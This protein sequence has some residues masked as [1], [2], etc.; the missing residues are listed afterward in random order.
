[1]SVYILNSNQIVA[2]AN[3]CVNNDIDWTGAYHHQ[4]K[5]NFIKLQ[6]EMKKIADTLHACNVDAFNYRYKE[7]E[8]P[9]QIEVS[10]AHAA[11]AP[12]SDKEIAQTLFSLDYNSD[13]QEDYEKTDGYRLINAMIRK[14]CYKTL[15]D[16]SLHPTHENFGPDAKLDGTT[17]PVSILAMMK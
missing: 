7:T 14:L 10:K 2:L 15:M 9:D 3:W 16:T 1:M 11:L 17:G 5:T 8:I 6:D 4:S 12:D 13:E